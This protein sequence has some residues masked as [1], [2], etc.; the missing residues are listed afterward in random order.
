[1]LCNMAWCPIAQCSMRRGQGSRERDGADLQPR[2]GAQRLCPSAERHALSG[3]G[4]PVLAV[5]PTK[6]DRE[7]LPPV[8]AS[9]TTPYRLSAKVLLT[10]WIP[11]EDCRNTLPTPVQPQ[12]SKVLPHI[13]CRIE[14]A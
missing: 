4:V 3:G 2:M 8:L 5:D 11:P 13:T 6:R 7:T 14:D 1:M 12:P 9:T 10:T